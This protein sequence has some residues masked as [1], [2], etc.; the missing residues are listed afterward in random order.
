MD[1]IITIKKRLKDKD[2]GW[3]ELVGNRKITKAVATEIAE[4]VSEDYL[5]ILRDAE[6][7][8][9]VVQPEK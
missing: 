5:S 2:W 3:S 8:Y 7:Q 6:I 4:L 1:V 9:E